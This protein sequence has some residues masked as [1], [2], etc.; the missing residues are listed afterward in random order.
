MTEQF[1]ITSDRQFS[2]TCALEPLPCLAGF[3]FAFR[4][5]AAL[6]AARVCGADPATG[7]AVSIVFEFFLLAAVLFSI[8]SEMYPKVRIVKLPAA[9]SA[10]LFLGVSCCSLLWSSTVSL[11]NSSLYWCAMCSDVVIVGTLLCSRPLGNT[12]ASLL[13]GY[14]W[15]ALAVAIVAWILP[16]QS[17]LRLGDE[18]LLGPNQIGYV[19]AMGFFFVQLLLREKVRASVFSAV[20][21]AITLLRSLSKTT[22]VAFLASEAFLLLRDRSMSRRT[23]LLIA[24]STLAI[25]AVF[26]G[27]LLS[28]YDVYMSAGNQSETLT[29]RLGVWAYFLAEAVQQPWI[30][31][32]FDSAWK[33][34]PPFGADQFEAAHAHNEV[35]QQF[36]AYGAAG[37]L[38][39]AGIYGSLFVQFRR[40]AKGSYRTFFMAFLLFALIRG[41]ADTDRFDLSLPLWSVL[42]MASLAECRAGVLQ[43][44]EAIVSHN[45]YQPTP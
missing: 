16:A 19:C 37:V 17:D 26:S 11:T 14:I 27:L 28:Y 7:T 10:F 21:L 32:G 9:R 41:I 3:Y 34:I 15:G 30:G 25:V 38:L 23:K 22:I 35:L 1:V 36:Y 33:V 29:G 18:E 12:A 4:T 43:T 2:V 45:R 20:L 40:M 31:H 13:Q 6:L 5:I 44:R 39:F 42:L 8:P 24:L